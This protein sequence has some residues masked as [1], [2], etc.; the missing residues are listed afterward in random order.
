MR[1]CTTSWWFRKHW[2]E[3]SS[4]IYMHA[5][6]MIFWHQFLCFQHL[7]TSFLFQWNVQNRGLLIFFVNRAELLSHIWS[8]L[9]PDIVLSWLLDKSH[10]PS[11][12]HNHEPEAG[13]N[14]ILKACVVHL[15]SK[16]APN[17]LQLFYISIIIIQT[18][19]FLGTKHNMGLSALQD[20][21]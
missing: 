1:L 9:V 4:L 6:C 16:W 13:F 19:I 15:V 20:L 17:G 8:Y 3:D 14:Y 21:Q 7:N 11:V 12:C 10:F 2:S 18:S 5:P